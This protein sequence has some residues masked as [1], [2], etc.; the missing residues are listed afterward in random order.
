VQQS[1]GFNS[2]Y[3]PSGALLSAG[4]KKPNHHTLATSAQNNGKESLKVH[5]FLRR[6][7]A[8]WSMH[9]V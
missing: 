4:A 5:F 1:D 9:C 7:C 6:I 2:G 3:F 8:S